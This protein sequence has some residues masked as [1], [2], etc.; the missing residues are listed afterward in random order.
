VQIARQSAALA[1]AR[2]LKVAGQLCELRCALGDLDFHRVSLDLNDVLQS[3]LLS[4]DLLGPPQRNGTAPEGHQI[5][6][7]VH[8][9]LAVVQ[10]VA[11][12]AGAFVSG[13]LIAWYR[14]LRA[15]L[16]PALLA[17]LLPE[18]LVAAMTAK[19]QRASPQSNTE[20]DP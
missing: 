5:R 19:F 12:I 13:G 18:L 3:L 1:C 11:L 7:A 2:G 20:T 15:L 6:L 9:A 16:K 14:P 4:L 17:G 10:P 8:A